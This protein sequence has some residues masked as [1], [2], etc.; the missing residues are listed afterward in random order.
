MSSKFVY[1]TYIRATP[2]KVWDA[3]LKSEFTRRYFFGVTF[4]TDWKV[5]SPW[6]MVHADGSV[7]DAGEVLEADPPKRLVLKW[8]NEYAHLKTEGFTRCTF[9]ISQAGSLTKLAVV[10]EARRNNSKTIEAVAGGWPMIL[11]NLKT[12]LETGKVLKFP[13]R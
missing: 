11:S 4:E 5:G 12:F 1:V 3:L 6:K 9:E 10:H 8:R 7:S 2:K 13:A